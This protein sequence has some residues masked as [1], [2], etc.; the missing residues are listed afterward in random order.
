MS[1]LLEHELEGLAVASRD[2]PTRTVGYVERSV[3]LGAWVQLTRDE[4]TIE[5]GWLGRLRRAPR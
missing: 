3:I 2:D 4:D 1:K 5:Q